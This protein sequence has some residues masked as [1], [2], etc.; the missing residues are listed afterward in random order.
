M[1]WAPWLRHQR[2]I[3]SSCMLWENR[4]FQKDSKTRDKGLK[5]SAINYPSWEKGLG[6]CFRR[7]LTKLCL[8]LLITCKWCGCFN[9]AKSLV[10]SS[11]NFLYLMLL[12]KGVNY[13][14]HE[15]LA[16]FTW[17]ILGR[18]WEELGPRHNRRQCNFLLDLRLSMFPPSRLSCTQRIWWCWKAPRTWLCRQLLR[19][20]QQVLR[21]AV[22]VDNNSRCTA[23][24]WCPQ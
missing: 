10:Q 24:R 12:T 17:Y 19:Y 15:S 14:C 22:Y 5:E 18:L 4:L 9:F 23:P 8:V 20:W 2:G 21:A 13:T 6:Q 3:N 1:G 11:P 7:T 16:N